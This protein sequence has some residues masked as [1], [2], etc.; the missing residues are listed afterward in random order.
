LSGS[1]LVWTLNVSD[2]NAGIILVSVNRT[3]IANTPQTV[4]LSSPITWTATSVGNPTTSITF[5]F[6]GD[7]GSLQ[8][9][10]FTITPGTGLALPGSVSGSGLVRTLN[11]SNVSAGTVMVSIDRAGISNIPR[12]V[13]LVTLGDI[14]WAA[15]AV[16]SPITTAI[17]FTFNRDPGSLSSWHFTITPETGSATAGSV[18]GSGLVRTLNVSNVS[19][20]TVMVSINQTGIVNTPQVLWVYAP[21]TWTAT[22]VG[23][24]ATAIN[25]VFSSD[26]GFLWATDFTIAPGTGSATRGTLS[27]SGLMRTLSISN[28]SAGTVMVT[29]NHFMVTNAPQTITF[30]A[31]GNMTINITGIPSAHNSRQALVYI[32]CPVTEEE[33]QGTIQSGSISVTFNGV[34]P[35]SYFV[36]IVIQGVGEFLG[37]SQRSLISGNNNV[38]WSSFIPA[39]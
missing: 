15:S 7:P 39:R 28:V 1:A 21:I 26:P 24:P 4:T 20:G 12:T 16:G 35:G 23:T 38:P 9:L 34:S 6:S 8:T 32:V 5:T 13:T 37:I 10:D 22:P 25:F 18:S 30:P 3:G 33:R 36:D 31:P 2:V 11:V 14:T 19:D 29:V 27:G 17:T